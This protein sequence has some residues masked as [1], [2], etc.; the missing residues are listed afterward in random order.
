MPKADH[1]AVLPA[2][3]ALKRVIIER[4]AHVTLGL[5]ARWLRCLVEVASPCKHLTQ[6]VVH[7]MCTIGS[8]P[9]PC[10][11]LPGMSLVHQQSCT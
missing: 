8:A 9:T 4:I 6:Q 7:H 1:S 10:A 2:H 3:C 11:G 5:Q